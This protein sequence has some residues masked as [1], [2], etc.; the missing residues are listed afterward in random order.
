MA[1]NRSG[2]QDSGDSHLK[3]DEG[4]SFNQSDSCNLISISSSPDAGALNSLSIESN[5]AYVRHERGLGYYNK[6]KNEYINIPANETKLKEFDEKLKPT[7]S[8]KV[9]SEKELEI[10]ASIT[11]HTL[12]PDKNFLLALLCAYRCIRSITRDIWSKCADN[13]LSIFNHFEHV[14]TQLNKIVEN[15]EVIIKNT[16]KYQEFYD[17]IFKLRNNA[18]LAQSFKKNTGESLLRQTLHAMASFIIDHFEEAEHPQFMRR[19][20]FLIE[21]IKSIKQKIEESLSKQG[22]DIDHWNNELKEKTRELAYLNEIHYINEARLY[23]LIPEKDFDV[24]QDFKLHLNRVNKG[25]PSFL[26]KDYHLVVYKLF[27]QKTIAI[28]FNTFKQNA[29]TLD[30]DVIKKVAADG[31]MFSPHEYFNK[32]NH[33]SLRH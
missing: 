13:G 26:H 30:L 5:M 31:L 21:E 33:N 12:L 28:D 9:L 15:I 24:A 11:G 19:K 7:E 17:L 27:Y 2:N 25:I 1:L 22:I 3:Q 14:P 16:T 32:N 8:S 10:I 23:H 18:E 29:S 20:K 6:R 4:N